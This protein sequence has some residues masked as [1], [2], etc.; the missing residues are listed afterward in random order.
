M[1]RSREMRSPGAAGG[2]DPYYNTNKGKSENTAGVL[3][4]VLVVSDA[5]GVGVRVLLEFYLR[6]FR[7]LAQT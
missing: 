1:L 4:R 6:P 7:L 3:A 2:A 5:S